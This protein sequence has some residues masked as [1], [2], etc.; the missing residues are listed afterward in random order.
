LILLVA[1][2]IGGAVVAVIKR[3]KELGGKEEKLEPNAE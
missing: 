3:F 2:A 1:T